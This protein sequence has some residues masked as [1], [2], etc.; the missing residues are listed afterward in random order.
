MGTTGYPVGYY[1]VDTP[2][3]VREWLKHE[4]TWD[5]VE[6]L[7]IAPGLKRR[8]NW[9]MAAKI[10]ETGKVRA[11]LAITSNRAKS[12]G[13]FYVKALDEK[14]GPYATDIPKRLFDMLT[15]LDDDE[16]YAIEWRERVIA[17]PVRG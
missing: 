14:V 11:L 16:T 5:A 7:D 8:S 1:Q 15:P 3:K 9:W 12:Q 4:F 17:G 6:V 10:K 2:D 13:M